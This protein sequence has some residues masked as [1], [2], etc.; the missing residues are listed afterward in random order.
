MKDYWND[1]TL[2]Q[3]WDKAERFNYIMAYID[4]KINGDDEDEEPD[5]EGSSGNIIV[6]VKNTDGESVA[7]ADVAVYAS[8]EPYEATTGSAG[9]CTIRDVPYGDYTIEAVAEGYNFT[10]ESITVDSAEIT[11]ELI[12]KPEA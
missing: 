2:V 3:K 7:N 12:L 9:G 6:S 11:R 8:G 10:V 5:D 4:S 1:L